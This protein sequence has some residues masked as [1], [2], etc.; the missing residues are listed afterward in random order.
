MNCVGISSIFQNN[1]QQPGVG[2][3]ASAPPLYPSLILTANGLAVG[4]ILLPV[5]VN[6]N[7]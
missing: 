2:G 7:L 1:T 5:C 4:G 6:L 3:G